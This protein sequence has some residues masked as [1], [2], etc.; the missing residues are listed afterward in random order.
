[1][2]TARAHRSLTTARNQQQ[3]QQQSL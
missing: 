2:R 1:M 3:Q